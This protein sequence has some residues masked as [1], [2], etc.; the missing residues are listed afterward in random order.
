MLTIIS[1]LFNHSVHGDIINPVL[2]DQSFTEQT[3]L[4]KCKYMVLYLLF[5]E[6][7]FLQYTMVYLLNLSNVFAACLQDLVETV[8]PTG[9]DSPWANVLRKDLRPTLST[10]RKA[11]TQ[12]ADSEVVATAKHPKATVEDFIGEIKNIK[13]V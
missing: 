4:G 1:V 10:K 12:T 2:C 11:S 7:L 5:Q 13:T 6:H 3:S 8:R 9:I